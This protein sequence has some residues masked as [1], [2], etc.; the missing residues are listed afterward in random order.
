MNLGT[1]DHL[2]CRVYHYD[3]FSKVLDVLSKWML[4]REELTMF[5]EGRIL[6]TLLQQNEPHA[7]LA[8]WAGKL[9]MN[10]LGTE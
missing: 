3:I 7:L 8:Y 6:A 10:T 5:V 4:R 1:S 2:W 9:A